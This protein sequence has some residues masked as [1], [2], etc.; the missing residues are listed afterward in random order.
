MLSHKFHWKI[1]DCDD[2]ETSVSKD[3]DEVLGDKD[4][5]QVNIVENDVILVDVN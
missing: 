3:T 2:N 5:R 1:W 4:G